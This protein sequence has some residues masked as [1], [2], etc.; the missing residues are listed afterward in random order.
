L[1][2]LITGQPAIIRGPG[3]NIHIFDWINPLIERGDIQ[4]IVDPRLDGEFNTNSAWKAM[5]IAMSCIAPV[6]IQ[7]P[8][9]SNVLA[10]L[11][12]CLAQERSRT[13][14][15]KGITSRIVLKRTPSELESE[16]APHAR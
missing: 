2:E 14:E 4:N 13:I 6:A 8:D 16:M 15:T 3:K 10:E 11:K 12:E 7:R 1:F 9:M 5:E